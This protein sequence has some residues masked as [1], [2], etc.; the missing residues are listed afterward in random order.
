MT[1]NDSPACYSCGIPSE[2]GRRPMTF[3]AMSMEGQHPALAQRNPPTVEM[4][5]CSECRARHELASLLVT[6]RPNGRDGT[7]TTDRLGA[8]LDALA[9]LGKPMPKQ[10][11]SIGPLLRHLTTP[12]SLARWA[13]RYAPTWTKGAKA[14]DANAEAWAHLTAQQRRALR[15]GYSRVLAERV[16]AS[17]PPVALT[18]PPA[19]EGKGSPVEGGC[20]FC[21]VPAVAMDAQRVVA[22]GGVEQARAEAWTPTSAD[23]TVLGGRTSGRLRGHLCPDCADSKEA[24]GSVGAGAIERAYERHMR[25]TGRGDELPSLGPDERLSGLRAW[26]VT[27]RTENHEPWQHIG[28]VRA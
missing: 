27:A 17:A 4:G 25:A 6:G 3:T 9:A 5:E 12:G 23:A 28:H 20:L 26:A 13:A 7:V 16:A 24:V 22:R 1:T 18:P 14:D 21:G 2:P 8:A 19:E 10:G 11:E 15:E